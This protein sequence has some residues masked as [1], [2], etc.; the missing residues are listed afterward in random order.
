MHRARK[1]QAGVHSEETISDDLGRKLILCIADQNKIG[2]F[3]H[4]LKGVSKQ[5]VRSYI[6]PETKVTLLHFAVLA[7]NIQGGE[8]L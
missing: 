3:K 8:R 5:S 7:G 2:R 4:L 6:E 1:A